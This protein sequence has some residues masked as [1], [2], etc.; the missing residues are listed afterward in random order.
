LD[1][2]FEFTIPFNNNRV[3]K[4]VINFSW[5]L[6]LS[7]LLSG[8]LTFED[9]KRIPYMPVHTFGL[10]LELPWKTAVKKLSGSLILSGRFETVRYADTSNITELKP[11]F[12]LNITYNQKVTENIAIFGKINNALN[13]HYVS[14]ADYPMPGIS[15]TLGMRM[16]LEFK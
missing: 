10:S 12:I 14:F 9:N 1:N 16:N 13:T 2:K 5:L 15:L 8:E 7:W 3:E 4:L 6:Q 11:Y